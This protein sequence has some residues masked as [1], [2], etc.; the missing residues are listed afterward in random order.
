MLV[1]E[2]IESIRTVSDYGLCRLC[3]LDVFISIREILGGCMR[4][5]T[6]TFVK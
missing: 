2:S 3:V 1:L 6:T 5:R 4:R